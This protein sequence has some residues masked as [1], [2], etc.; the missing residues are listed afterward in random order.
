MHYHKIFI[1]ILLNYV[2]VIFCSFFKL[3]WYGEIGRHSDFKK[4]THKIIV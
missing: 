1:K 2:Y 4:T 3:L